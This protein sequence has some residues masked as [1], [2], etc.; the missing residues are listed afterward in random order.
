MT[1]TGTMRWLA[2]LGIVLALTLPAVL[3]ACGGDE[4]PASPGTEAATSTPMPGDAPTAT[5]KPRP[6]VTTRPLL[7]IGRTSAATDREALVALYNAT[8]GPNWEYDENW[9]SGRVPGRMVRR[10]N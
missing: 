9:L 5:D 3:I 8:D 10:R 6:T 2:L 1:S 4:P 7:T